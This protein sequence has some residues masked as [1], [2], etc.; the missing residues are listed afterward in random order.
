MYQGNQPYHQRLERANHQAAYHVD[1][2]CGSS[3]HG[4]STTIQR[5]LQ[6]NNLYQAIAQVQACINARRAE[7]QRRVAPDPA[8]NN[9]IQTLENFR[10]GLN[11]LQNSQLYE[12]YYNETLVYYSDYDGFTITIGG[13][14]MGGNTTKRKTS[15]RK[16][17]KRKTSK[18][19]NKYKSDNHNHR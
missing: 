14:K 11:R 4:L 15:K 6:A 3:F 2:I 17:S 19:R 8:H 1:H 18:L 12:T 5:F 13:H 7:I 16:T 10:A 9:A